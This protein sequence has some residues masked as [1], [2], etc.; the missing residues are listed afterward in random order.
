MNKEM[1]EGSVPFIYNRIGHKTKAEQMVETFRKSVD[2]W[3]TLPLIEYGKKMDQFPEFL[4]R[5]ELK[6]YEEKDGGDEILP[7]V[8]KDDIERLKA[9]LEL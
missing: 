4:E 3:D 7:G 5:D 9:K 8:T 1:L 2:F 6:E